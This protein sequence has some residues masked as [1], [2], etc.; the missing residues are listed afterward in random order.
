MDFSLIIPKKPYS[1]ALSQGLFEKIRKTDAD[2]A[3]ATA[4]R[5]KQNEPKDHLPR[6]VLYLLRIR[7]FRNFIKVRRCFLDDIPQSVEGVHPLI[8]PFDFMR[9]DTEV[10]VQ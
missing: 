8:A 6:L 9:H 10:E 2:E 1:I 4:Y 7:R 3:H 5:A